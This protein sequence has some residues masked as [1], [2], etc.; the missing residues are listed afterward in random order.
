ML[1]IIVDIIIFAIAIIGIRNFSFG[2]FLALVSGI[3]FPPYV[4]FVAGP[5][6]LAINDFILLALTLSFLLNRP[7]KMFNDRL[8]FPRKLMAY[9]LFYYGT[10]FLLILL[11][12][13][14]TPF[15]YQ[16]SS[17]LKTLGQNGLFIFFAYYA[18]KNFKLSHL[19]ILFN[20]A[21]V[22]GLYGIFVYI[23]KFNPFIDALSNLYVGENRFE[24]FLEQIRGGLVGRTS[25]TLDHPLTWGQ[26]WGVLL[27]LYFIYKN[28]IS[29]KVVLYAFPILAVGNI[30]FSGSRTSIV[31]LCCILGFYLF[32]IG[33][34]KM[35]KY[36]VLVILSFF[37]L[38]IP[39]R[40]IQYTEGLVKYVEAGLFFWDNTYSDAA[41]INGSSVSM[42]S[43]QLE[44]ALIIASN[45][46]IGGLGFNSVKYFTTSSFDGMRGFESVIFTKIVEQGILGLILYFISLS[47]FIS[48]VFKYVSNDKRLLWIGY[49]FSYFVSIVFTGIQNTWI[50]FFFSSFFVIAQQKFFF[51]RHA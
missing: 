26:M 22:A 35:L 20:C 48:W 4:R 14:L 23:T 42:R 45:N 32:S 5:I 36:S 27:S 2:F 30:V 1:K 40:N 46:P 11:S 39:L 33:R 44:T 15:D 41:D 34:K 17:Y 31:V 47:I 29:R 16:I 13:D 43:E 50:F 10:S 24:F 8:C 7:W 28:Y 49:F 19:D 51:K 37:V 25:G 18:L 12:S 38:L 21:A 9:F 6:N 3:L